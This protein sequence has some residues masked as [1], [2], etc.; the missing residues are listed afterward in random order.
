MEPIGSMSATARNQ[1]LLARKICQLFSDGL[2]LD[3]DVVHYL[4]STFSGHDIQILETVLQDPW[5][6]ERGPL[7]ELLYFPDESIQIRLEGF[8][9]RAAFDKK[10]E[11]AVL[12]HLEATPTETV[13]FFPGG[14]SGWRIETPADGAAAFTERLK[15]FSNLDQRLIAAIQSRIPAS[16][17][18]RYKVSIR[19]AAFSRQDSHIAGLEAFLLKSDVA[20]PNFLHRFRFFLQFLN[21]WTGGEDL[22]QALVQKKRLYLKQLHKASQV[23]ARRQNRNVETLMVMGIRSPHAD[24]LEIAD[25]IAMIDDIGLYLF[26]RSLYVNESHPGSGR[27]P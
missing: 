4:D 3:Q 24:R 27:L 21:E 9:E 8:L 13:F 6:C 26:G 2:T 25:K 10:D 23:E 22:W 16:E 18:N 17:R 19:N 20:C 7:I 15:I 14:K 1:H 5:N 12:E 11:A